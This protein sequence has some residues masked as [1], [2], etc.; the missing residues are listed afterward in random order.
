MARH[1]ARVY[2]VDNIEFVQADVPTW[3]AERAD[4]VARKAA[5][6]V[7]VVFMSPAWGGPAYSSSASY[8]LAELKPLPG[9]ELVSLAR[10]LTSDIALFLPRNVDLDDGALMR[11]RLPDVSQSKRSAAR[12]T[13]S[14][15]WKRPS[16]RSSSK[17][18]PCISAT[19]SA[20]LRSL[21]YH[22][23]PLR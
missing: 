12:P 14:S 4:A 20:P 23:E 17:P 15:S 18:S 22:I 16:C 1:N 10:R 11:I 8:P 19:S 21:L 3:L 2:G 9:A 6:P 7:E 5:P 13:A